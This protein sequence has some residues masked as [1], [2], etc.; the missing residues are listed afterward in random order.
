MFPNFNAVENSYWN[1][2]FCQ[3][4]QVTVNC[5]ERYWNQFLKANCETSLK[6]FL[7]FLAVVSLVGCFSSVQT[8]VISLAVEVIF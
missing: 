1:I 5:I 7:S 6:T 2:I 4:W 8:E 3:Y